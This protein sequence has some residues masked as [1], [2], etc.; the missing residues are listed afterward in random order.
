MVVGLRIT[1]G[2]HGQMLFGASCETRSD[3]VL[4]SLFKANK[5]LIYELLPRECSSTDW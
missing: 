3:V 5:D 4:V 1:L 2:S